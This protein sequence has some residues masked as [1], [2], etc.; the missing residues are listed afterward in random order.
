MD[1]LQLQ[2]QQSQQPQQQI[3]I[4]DIDMSILD[5][6]YYLLWNINDP[7][8]IYYMCLD[9]YIKMLTIENKK[10]FK[11][12]YYRELLKKEK[13]YTANT[14][15][16][17]HT[18]FYTI[19]KELFATFQLSIENFNKYLRSNAT[20]EFFTKNY[21]IDYKK[22]IHINEEDINLYNKI[23][24]LLY[25]LPAQRLYECPD[26]NCRAQHIAEIKNGITKE[27]N[28]HILC[29]RFIHATIMNKC[30]YVCPYGPICPKPKTCTINNT[31]NVINIHG[32]VF[33]CSRC[34]D[35][36][37]FANNSTCFSCI[38]RSRKQQP[39][40]QPPK[41]LPKEPQMQ[42]KRKI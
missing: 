18:K 8:E 31:L 15:I 1:S 11:F 9:Q 25:N 12:A 41:Q 17:I 36:W 4:D 21:N 20:Y 6:N 23:Q 26:E 7:K 19:I 5:S 32:G 35:N 2:L 10:N 3:I 22:L 14:I 27:T 29:C 34:N 13:Q 28:D 30:C 16:L 24:Y 38:D 33:P 42:K 37:S 39:P 40:P